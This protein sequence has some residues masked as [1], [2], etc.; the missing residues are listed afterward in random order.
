MLD[1]VISHQCEGTIVFHPP[2][3]KC[4]IHIPVCLSMFQVI[5]NPTDPLIS[6]T[7]Y[8]W[9]RSLCQFLHTLSICLFTKFNIPLV[10]A[11]YC[12]TITY[13]T[14]LSMCMIPSH[15]SPPIH[16]VPH[17]SNVPLSTI[18][19]PP[20]KSPLSA[21]YFTPIILLSNKF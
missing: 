17:G 1:T 14:L 4:Y 12:T 13:G 19:H 5:H 2:F 3:I 6:I 10:S 20:Q 16:R 7:V 18:L 11:Y 8:P 9:C 15:W 21:K